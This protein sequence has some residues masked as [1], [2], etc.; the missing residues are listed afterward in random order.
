MAESQTSFEALWKF[1]RDSGFVYEAKEGKLRP[2][3][4]EI[5]DTWDKLLQADG[6]VFK[7]FTHVKG[8][9][10]RSA[11]AI[12]RYYHKSWMIHHMASLTDPWGMKLVLAR[13]IKWMM[14]NQDLDHG[15]FY[16]R[17]N[18]SRADVR[19]SNLGKLL[20]KSGA[21]VSTHKVFDYFY[22]PAG[23]GP[24]PA[25]EA[26]ANIY[27]VQERLLG[28]AADLL[29]QVVDPHEIDLR[30]LGGGN[31]ALAGLDALYRRHDLRRRREVF[32][33]EV[34]GRVQAV[35]L[36]EDAS[37]GLNFSHFFNKFHLY[38]VGDEM[39]F[40]QRTALCG[41]V[42]DYLMAHCRRRGQDFLVCLCPPEQS[43]LFRA[44]GYRS[45]K[46]YACMSI[47]R[48]LEDSLTLQH[49]NNFYSRR[50][51]AIR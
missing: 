41:Q 26:I 37:L 51:D 13:A 40:A 32:S 7:L 30:S 12:T 8:G 48:Q 10:I 46:Q 33:A 47:A 14:A 28:L 50:M 35:V 31:L 49:F 17:P 29:A 25:G 43:E 19:F 34:G 38:F 44:L 5:A 4:A 20:E 36:L 15:I 39:D 45:H 6:S 2:H 18:N 21:E 23:D 27:P 24:R 22:F 3:L 11:L 1:Y 16:W 42:L 9:H